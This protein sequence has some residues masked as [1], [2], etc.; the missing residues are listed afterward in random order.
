MV[1]G[2][3]VHTGVGFPLRRFNVDISDGELLLKSARI[4]AVSLT[5]GAGLV[6][7]RGLFHPA[8]RVCVTP[9]PGEPNVD[10]R[11]QTAQRAAER[12]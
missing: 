11:E 6:P 2:Q 10:L 1:K 9:G 7:F 12:L 8:R 5:D 3:A 4:V